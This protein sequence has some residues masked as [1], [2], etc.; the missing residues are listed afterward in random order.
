MTSSIF[1]ATST[2]IS[3]S[4]WGSLLTTAR[5]YTADRRGYSHAVGRSRPGMVL[6]PAGGAD[7][8]VV[9]FAA[10]LQHTCTGRKSEGWILM[11]DIMLFS[12]S[13]LDK[14]PIGEE[15]RLTEGFSIFELYENHGYKYS[16]SSP[17]SSMR[18]SESKTTRS[19]KQWIPDQ[20][21]PDGI[22]GVNEV[23]VERDFS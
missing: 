11:E 15:T 7:R 12:I 17:C 3:S 22:S 8:N 13:T 4:L 6:L 18:K 21:F 9:Y 23:F 2:R 5:R 16:I 1:Q 14:K 20:M 10:A 19:Y